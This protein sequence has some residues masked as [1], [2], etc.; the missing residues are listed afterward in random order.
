MGKNSQKTIDTVYF[1]HRY[2]DLDTIKEKAAGLISVSVLIALIT[3][4]ILLF[5]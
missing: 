3:A 2:V 5:L 4:S 1:N